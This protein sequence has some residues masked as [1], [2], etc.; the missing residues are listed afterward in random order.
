MD[1]MDTDF[2]RRQWE[3]FSSAPIA[4]VGFLAVGAVAAWWFRGSVD[5]GETK[6]LRAQVEGLREQINALEQRLKLAGELEQ[7]A[8]RATQSAKEDLATLKE[9]MKDR[10]PWGT[11]VTTTST[12]EGRFREI[13]NAQERVLGTVQ[14]S[15]GTGVITGLEQIGS[16]GLVLAQPPTDHKAKTETPPSPKVS[17]LAAILARGRNHTRNPP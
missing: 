15:G 10:V 8:I 14:P 6:R 17:G 12:V 11:M 4:C 9:Q 3:A 13:E 16:L 1:P 2:W 7:T 5:Q